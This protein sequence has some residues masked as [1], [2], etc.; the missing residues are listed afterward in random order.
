VIIAVS[1]RSNIVQDVQVLEEVTHLITRVIKLQ[2]VTTLK[3]LSYSF[4]IEK[5][6]Q[7]SSVSVSESASITA[8][9]ARDTPD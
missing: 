2:D 1:I 7:N 8:V 5:R 3:W 9:Q 6:C 4:I